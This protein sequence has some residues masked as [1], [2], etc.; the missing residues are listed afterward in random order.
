V[1][2]PVKYTARPLLSVKYRGFTFD[3]LRTPLIPWNPR[4]AWPS[5]ADDEGA[6]D[7]I[8]PEVEGLLT[9]LVL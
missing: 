7:E 4:A 2:D 5:V 3:L 6:F 1:W 9:F 8:K